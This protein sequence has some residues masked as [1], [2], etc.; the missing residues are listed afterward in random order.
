MEVLDRIHL[1][2]LGGSGELGAGPSAGV[3]CVQGQDRGSFADSG[4]PDL[5]PSASNSWRY[6]RRSLVLASR[7]Q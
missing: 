3:Y 2:P 4:F 1:I 6:S 7:R 5:E